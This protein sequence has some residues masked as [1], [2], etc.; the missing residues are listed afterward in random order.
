M[1]F[2]N[3]ADASEWL[4]FVMETQAAGNGRGLV[5]GRIY[6]QDGTLAVVCQQEGVVR[7]QVASRAKL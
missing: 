1:H 7:A 4:L 3:A 2:Y 5:H 6:R